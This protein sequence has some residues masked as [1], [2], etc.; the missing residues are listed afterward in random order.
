MPIVLTKLHSTGISL[1]GKVFLG[2][3]LASCLLVNDITKEGI[4]RSTHRLLPIW[5]IKKSMD[6]KANVK[7]L[8]KE[9]KVGVKERSNT[10]HI[11]LITIE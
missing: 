10:T 6:R 9:K 3:K 5:W 7:K 4:S 2:P 11:K 1:P 8:H